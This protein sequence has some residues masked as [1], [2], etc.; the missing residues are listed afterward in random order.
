MD[1]PYDCA[2]AAAAAAAASSSR[3]ATRRAIGA[4]ARGTGSAGVA[5]SAQLASP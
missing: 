3:S 1:L 2:A 5:R 4:A